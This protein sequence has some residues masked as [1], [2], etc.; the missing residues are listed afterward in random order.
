M[1]TDWNL[2]RAAVNAAV[3]A[4]EAY[5][6]LNLR[7]ED[8]ARQTARPG[9]TVSDV[10]TSAWTYP[11]SLKYE[12]VRARHDVNASAPYRSDRARIMREI[13]ALCAELIDAPVDTPLPNDG[14]GPGSIRELVTGLTS[15]YSGVM[16]PLLRSA[17]TAPEES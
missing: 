2:V 5:E 10:A 9:V 7:E 12:I 6:N 15:W 8:R 14:A 3:D 11:E 1:S 13:G 16:T 17:A 4:C